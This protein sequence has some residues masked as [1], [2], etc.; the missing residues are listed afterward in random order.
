MDTDE[1]STQAYNAIIITA[2]KFNHNLT[3]EFGL[4]SYQ[5]K[6]ESEYLQKANQLIKEWGEDLEDS[7]EEIF[8]DVQHPT[9]QGF[10]KVLNEISNN[11]SKVLEIP[12]EE[13]TFEF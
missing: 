3:L 6:N 7:I 13:R 9:K 4:L 12:L 10:K 8:F 2:E 11:I 1:L 5:C